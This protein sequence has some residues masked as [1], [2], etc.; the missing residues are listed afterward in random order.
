MGT[1]LGPKYIPY[2]YMDPL[3]HACVPQR[4]YRRLSPPVAKQ[5]PPA[6]GDQG[7][8]LDLYTIGFNGVSPRV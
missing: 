4:V 6:P 3:G 8:S 1:P 2:T 7:P 5:S